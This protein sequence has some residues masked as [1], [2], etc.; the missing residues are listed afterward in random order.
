[1]AV[2][3][4][5]WRF[6]YLIVVGIATLWLGWQCLG[7]R[8]DHDNRSMNADLAELESGEARFREL[9][10]Q[11]ESILVAVSRDEL[12]SESGK[13]F[14]SR[15]VGDLSAIDGVSEVRSPVDFGFEVPEHL[16]GLLVSKDRKTAG[17][18]LL[19]KDFSDDASGLDRLVDDLEATMAKHRRP[20]AHIAVAGIPLQ[21]HEAARLV[22]R[23]QRIF[24]PLCFVVLG[25]VLLFVTRHLSGMLLPLGFALLTIVW[26][27][28]LYAWSGRSLNMITSLLP[29]VIMTLSASTTIHLY[30]EW[31]HI[32]E[33]DRLKRIT[34]ALRTLFMPCLLASGTTVIG[35][36]SLLLNDTPAVRSFGLFAAIGVAISFVIGLS[37]MA[38]ALS[39]CGIPKENHHREGVLGKALTRLL[40]GVAELAIRHPVAIVL[41]SLL[42]CGLG[43]SGALRVNSNTD[44]LQFLGAKSRLVQ[45][46]R[47]IDEHLT[48]T[49]VIELLV[50][51][52]DGEP[53]S[54]PEEMIPLAEFEDALRQLPHVKHVIGLVDV[55][56][57][58]LP[59]ADS[60]RSFLSEDSKTLRITLAAD[61]VGTREGAELVD[62]I[63]E[64]AADKL[65]DD[66]KVAE[67]GAFYRIVDESNHLTTSQVQSFG[68]ALGFILLSIGLFFRS[69][70]VMA[71]AILPNV[72]P[73]LLAA[74][75]MGYGGIDL[76]TGTSMIASVMIGI[77]VDD[78]IHFISAFRRNYQG[79]VDA[80]IR[81]TMSSTG[82]SLIATTLA[83]S[84]GFWVAIFGSFQPTVHFALLSGITMWFALAFD[85]VVLPACLKLGYRRR[86]VSIP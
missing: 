75:I 48:G 4:Q 24:S 7:L 55:P 3:L 85:L 25:V 56:R 72:A 5:R 30:M 44:L 20:G 83:L 74:A 43:V 28:G 18:R 78:T 67:T 77:A 36:L 47:F 16:V 32:E 1:M 71:L 58:V 70:R 84:L 46:T 41:V 13:D 31:R 26:T 68:A 21:K 64:E 60:M 17:I 40:S 10:G 54:G 45:D 2:F 82:L 6:L 39:F 61:S 19:L 81:T 51:R 73:L 33:Q 11:G 69:F 37:G 22:L 42:L 62:S 79:D 15:I 34:V 12:F 38:V 50:D 49:G 59:D 66:F 63:R 35:F 65:G 53:F 8:V 76:S 29:P 57:E 27:L 9:F 23:D 52:A 86:P 14:L 80:A